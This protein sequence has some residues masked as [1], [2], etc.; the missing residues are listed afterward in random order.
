MEEMPDLTTC[1]SVQYYI[2]EP[3]CREDNP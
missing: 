3:T 2:Y 1:V